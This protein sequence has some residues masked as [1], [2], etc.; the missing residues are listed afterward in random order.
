MALTSSTMPALGSPL[1]KFQLHDPVTGTTRDS[2]EFGTPL[3]VMFLCNHCPFVVHV[4]DGLLALTREYLD[5][6]VAFVAIN[7]NDVESYPADAPD[8]MA[9]LARDKAFGF[10][11]LFDADQSVARAFG[12]ACTPD[13]F[14]YDAARTLAYRG[15]LDRSRPG[16]GVPVTGADLR[17]ALDALLAGQRPSEQQRPSAGCNIKWRK[18]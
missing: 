11:F 5:R 16:N 14:V 1:P 17:A 6:G 10:P 15:Q 3:V 9:E 8:R 18:S 7:S 13:F 4:L 12:A 2:D